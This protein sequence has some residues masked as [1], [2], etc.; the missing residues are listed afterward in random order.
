MGRPSEGWKVKYKR[1]WAYVHFTWQGHR[2]RI[3]LDTNDRGREAQDR[4]A[5]AYA[6]VV[7]GKRRAL[8]RQ[9]GILLDLAE[10]LDQWIT[11]KRTSVH[12]TFVKTLDGYGRLF[13]ERFGSLDRITEASATTFGLER[14][15]EALRTTV[16]RELSYLR[17]FLAWCELHGALTEV[18]KVPKLPPKA[19]GTRTGTQRA[20]AVHISEEEAKAILALLPEQSKTINGRR[21]PLRSR[22]AFMWETA[23]RPETLSRLRVPDNWRPGATHLELA[24]EDDKARWGRAVDLT[25]AAVRILKDVAPAEGVV[26]GRHCFYKWLKWAAAQ[27]LGPVRG[28]KFAPYDFRHGRAME[29]LDEH[30]PMR[31]V[32]YMLGHKRVSTTD[33]YLAPDRKAGAA[34]LSA[35]A[36]NKR[37]IKTPARK[38]ASKGRRK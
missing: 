22:F 30:A 35:K 15:G 25:P 38:R 10:L 6:E 32:S 29:R 14:L 3:A 28:A 12:P 17:A 13:V 8:K 36:H 23:L 37:T 18:P 24:D 9:P 16:L 34:A 31:G 33:K 11:S 26:F 20:R 1:G 2:H 27:V 19:K 4:A 7:S 21:W 5:T